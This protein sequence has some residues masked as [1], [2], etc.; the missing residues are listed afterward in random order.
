MDWR[1]EI[2]RDREV[3]RRIVAMLLGFAHLAARSDHL[4]FA[5]R[6]PLLWI[7][8]HAERA[9]HEM[10]FVPAGSDGLALAPGSG[11]MPASPSQAE[12]CQLTPG[13]M[14]A[15]SFWRIA[16]SL[17]NMLRDDRRRALR[18]ASCVDPGTHGPGVHHV[19][20]RI[21]ASAPQRRTFAALV[22]LDT[23]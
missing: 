5:L 4:H 13:Q 7:L 17:Q 3:V 16:V 8:R 20:S 6:F 11:R 21:A 15:L 10:I 19:A 1:S 9:A 18:G 22:R 2:G 23:S 12:A 14:L